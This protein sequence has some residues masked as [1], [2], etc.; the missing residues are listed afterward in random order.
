MTTLV[1]EENGK[2]IK[3]KR[4]YHKVLEAKLVPAENIVISLY[5]EFIENESEEV[6]KNDCEINASKRLLERLK[7]D[8][9]K[10]PVC[11]QGDALYAAESIMK[12][13]N[14]NHWKLYPDAK[15]NRQKALAESYGYI[16]SGGGRME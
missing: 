15:E 4:Y 10:L 14:K 16:Q 13:C 8:Y 2:E 3:V 11:L 5:T 6:S 12:I 7:R 9:P 1:R